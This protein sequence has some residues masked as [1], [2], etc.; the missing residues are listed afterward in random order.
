MLLLLVPYVNM[1]TKIITCPLGSLPEV[2]MSFHLLGIEHDV[3]GFYDFLDCQSQV[4]SNDLLPERLA[5]L[6]R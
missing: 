3:Y 4:L 5:A 1:L 6:Q 2:F